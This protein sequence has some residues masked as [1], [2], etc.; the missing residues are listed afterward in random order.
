MGTATGAMNFFRAPAAAAIFL[1]TAFV[2][3]I[4]LPERPLRG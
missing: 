3:L 4:K 1:V 2:A